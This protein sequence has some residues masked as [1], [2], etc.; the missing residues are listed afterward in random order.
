M[1]HPCGGRHLETRRT[2]HWNWPYIEGNRKAKKHSKTS[3]DSLG[4]EG[5]FFLACTVLL[6]LGL[7]PQTPGPNPSGQVSFKRANDATRT[8]SGPLEI[9]LQT[10]QQSGSQAFAELGLHLAKVVK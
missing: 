9:C 2:G 8:N 7:K 6:V 10:G 4:G 1:E 3:F 5:N